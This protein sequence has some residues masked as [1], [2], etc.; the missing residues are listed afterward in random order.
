MMYRR[1]CSGIA[2][3]QTL[4]VAAML[5]VIVM[6]FAQQANKALKAAEMV[7]A[8]SQ[9]RI[10]AV[11][12]EAYLQLALLTG[13][14]TEFL[15]AGF[16]NRAST[17][18]SLGRGQVQLQDLAGLVSVSAPVGDRL[19]ALLVAAGLDDSHASR[20]VD[21]LNDWQDRNNE[22]LLLGAEQADY[23]N[24]QIVRNNLLQSEDELRFVQG[25]DQVIF[26]KISQAIT[27]YPSPYLNPL[28]A[29]SI[30]LQSLVS[31][32]SKVAELT[33]LRLQNKL[34]WDQFFRITGLQMSESFQPIYGQAVRYHLF[35]NQHETSIDIKKEIVIN[36][37][38]ETPISLWKRN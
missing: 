10:D 14:E 38:G 13:N 12:A 33:A 31:N 27:L 22:K 21:T 3:I 9:A 24:G 37:Y 16:F 18:F 36:P 19:Q 29:P 8:Q 34:D 17:P 35:V 4:M 20:L 25:M 32:P 7:D 11:S 30:V 26:N 15:T 5:A 23:K 2:L 1:F 6:S 28:T